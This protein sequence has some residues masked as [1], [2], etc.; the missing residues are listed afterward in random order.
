MNDFR[1]PLISTDESDAE[2]A[3]GML[4]KAEEMRSNIS[5]VEFKKG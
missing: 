4:R 3:R 2:L 5:S 1:P